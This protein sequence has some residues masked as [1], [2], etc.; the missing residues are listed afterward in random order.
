MPCQHGKVRV[1]PRRSGA[2]TVICILTWPDRT[3]P[4]ASSSACV[5]RGNLKEWWPTGDGI[6][7]G[8]ALAHGGAEKGRVVYFLERGLGDQQLAHAAALL[9]VPDQG[10]ILVR[11]LCYRQQIS[12]PYATLSRYTLLS[13]AHEA[14]RSARRPGIEWKTPTDSVGAMMS[15]RPEFTRQPSNDRDHAML[16]WRLD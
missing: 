4:Y 15:E 5:E 1:T 16:R 10:P 14:A 7:I 8:L 2:E 12:D 6:A 11:R 13:A 3:R 9:H